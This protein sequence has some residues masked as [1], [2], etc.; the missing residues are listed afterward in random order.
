[1]KIAGDSPSWSEFR[2]GYID[3]VPQVFQPSH[4]P[5]GRALAIKL[6]Q[7]LRPQIVIHV[8]T[9]LEIVGNL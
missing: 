4:Q 8:P 6:I 7:I 1:M 5:F 9:Y 2:L 3:G